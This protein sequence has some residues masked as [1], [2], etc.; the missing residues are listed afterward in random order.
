MAPPP[1]PIGGY[2]AAGGK[3]IA[4]NDELVAVGGQSPDRVSADTA[5]QGVPGCT[6]PPGNAV[7]AS[8]VSVPELTAGDQLAVVYCQCR[9]AH[10]IAGEA[11]PERL[12]GF[13][14]PLGDAMGRSTT[15]RAESSP[16]DQTPSVHGE[17]VGT[18]VQAFT[19]R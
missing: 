9:D 16:D 13:A 6:I 5:A 12:P 19:Q 4:S 8:A 17:C 15:G 10:H 14:V 2:A 7:S 1:G 18:V 11:Q 3:K